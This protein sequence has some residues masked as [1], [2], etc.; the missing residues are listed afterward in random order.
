[1]PFQLQLFTNYNKYFFRMG[2]KG[3]YIYYYYGGA[4]KTLLWE[5]IRQTVAH[6]DC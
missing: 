4:L 1:M 6:S 2:I 3:I 5:A